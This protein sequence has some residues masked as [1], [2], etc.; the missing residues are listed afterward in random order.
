MRALK[1]SINALS[2]MMPA[3]QN[4]DAR[5]LQPCVVKDPFLLGVNH[6]SR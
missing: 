4:G 5:S 3:T 2:G 1:A 6:D